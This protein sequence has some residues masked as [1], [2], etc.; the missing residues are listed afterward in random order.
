MKN[1]K[2]LKILIATLLGLFF[3][4]CTYGFIYETIFYRINDG[5]WLRRGT[6]FGPFIQIY[7][8]GGIFIYFLCHKL[9]GHPIKTALISGIVCGA[10]EYI[11]GW[12]MYVTMDGFRS[13]DYNTE[14]WNWGNINGFICFRSVA[15]FALSGV[16]LIE[17]VLPI[18]NWL[19]NKIGDDK[20]FWILTIL[21]TICF[22]D[23]FY[24][25]IMTKFFPSIENAMDWWTRHGW[26]NKERGLNI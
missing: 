19:R 21:G 9:K 1:K 3:V 10:F 23:C 17:F 20:Y 6:C 26:I 25:D 22:A 7:G 12:L 18:F 8:Y 5:I 15:V 11:V 14:I 16:I 4:S 2:E 24:N 13:W